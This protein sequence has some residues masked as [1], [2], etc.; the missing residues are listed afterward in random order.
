M[1]EI[2]ELPILEVISPQGQVTR[3]EISTSPVVLGRL[4]DCDVQLD[5]QRVSRKHAQIARDEQGGWTVRDL[6]SRNHTRVNG[7]IVSER[8]LKHDDLIEIGQFQMRIFWPSQETA[9]GTARSTT[10]SHQEPQTTDFRTLSS[11]PA[12][13]LNA[14]SLAKI[15]ALG[16]HLMEIAEFRQRLVE[17]CQTLVGEGLSSDCAVVVR[18]AGNED[19]HPQLLCPYQ[20]RAGGSA[21][22]GISRA[23]VQAAVAGQ[24]PILAG[25]SVASGLTISF[26]DAERGVTAIIA[27]PLR[28]EPDFADILYATMPHEF[29][30][31]DCLALLTLAAEQSKKAELQIE[32]RKTTQDNALAQHELQRA[33]KIQLSLVPRNPTASGLEVAIGFEP[34]LWIGGDYANVITAPSGKVALVIADVSGK[35]LSAAMVATGVHSVVDRSIRAGESLPEMAQDLDQFLINSMDR[36]SHL[37]L[38]A[39]LFDPKTG[40]AEYLNA[41]HPPILIANRAGEIRQLSFGN[42]PPLG[43]LATSP[44]I[45]QAQLEEGDLLLLYTDGLTEI[46]S[47]DGKML[48]VEGVKTLLAELFSANPQAPLAQLRD[49]LTEKLDEMRGSS[50]MAD[51]RTFLLAR[52]L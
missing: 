42:N 47:A 29:G 21:P 38:L 10:W 17:L 48:G 50:P 8:L 2:P 32:A 36:Q 6:E 18:V 15:S 14:A 27:C 31:L 43:V 41:G 52:R 20:I 11:S 9:T 33:R 7:E 3:H 34:C 30:T 51:D 49:E 5:S 35:G 12:R 39:V 1:S 24:Q 16:S 19:A 23:V 26:T 25:G 45:E 46:F 40:G 37:T 44:V 4:S 28:I 13:R 22:S